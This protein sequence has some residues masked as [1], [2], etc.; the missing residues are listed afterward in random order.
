MFV[1]DLLGRLTFCITITEIQKIDGYFFGGQITNI[2]QASNIE[3]YL[4]KERKENER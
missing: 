4:L 2:L 1:R 3:E